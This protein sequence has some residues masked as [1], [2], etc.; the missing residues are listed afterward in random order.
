MLDADKYIDRLREI[1]KKRHQ[2]FWSSDAFT[3]S[4]LQSKYKIISE[5]LYNIRNRLDDLIKDYD[6]DFD[7]TME[8]ME[9]E[10]SS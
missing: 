9:K 4:D 7:K 3:K 6:K 10:T 1:A 2:D 8:E 5:A